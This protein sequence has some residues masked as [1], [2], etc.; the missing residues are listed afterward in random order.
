[1]DRQS[2]WSFFL[3]IVTMA[4]LQH[5]CISVY[6]YQPLGGMRRSY[7]VS[8]QEQNFKG[9]SLRLKCLKSATID[10]FQAEELCEKMRV[11]FESQGALIK[12]ASNK[13]TEDDSQQKPDLSIVFS[14]KKIY[15]VENSWLWPVSFF[16]FTLIPVEQEFAVEQSMQIVDGSGQLLKTEN[17]QARFVWVWGLGYWAINGLLN[18]TVR[19]DFENVTEETVKRDFSQDFY[20]QVSQTLYNASSTLAFRTQVRK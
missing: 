10:A 20:S 6:H 2:L 13:E 8:Y 16:T 17:F 19:S 15:D 11:L 9:L 5:G 4:A 1:M 3:C 12:D 18:W 14:A 7:L